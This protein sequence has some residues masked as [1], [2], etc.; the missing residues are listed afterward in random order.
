MTDALTASV[1]QTIGASTKM[2]DKILKE[3]ERVCEIMFPDS[4]EDQCLLHHHLALFADF[5][6]VLAIKR[7]RDEMSTESYPNYLPEE[8]KH[9]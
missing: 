8:I 9:G 6:E 7:F 4:E 5:V 2:E 1:S 3:A